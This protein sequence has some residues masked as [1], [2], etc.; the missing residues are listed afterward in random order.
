MLRAQIV[1]VIPSLEIHSISQLIFN[2]KFSALTV[3]YDYIV[4]EVAPNS[5]KE[6]HSLIAGIQALYKYT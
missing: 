1:N 5:I 6:I 4:S 3:L 2:V